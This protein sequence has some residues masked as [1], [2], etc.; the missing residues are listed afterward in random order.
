MG[1]EFK[2]QLPLRVRLQPGNF[3]AQWA[4]LARLRDEVHVTQDD[5]TIAEDA[6]NATPVWMVDAAQRPTSGSVPKYY[7]STEAV[8][9][10]TVEDVHN[11]QCQVS[12]GMGSPLWLKQSDGS[13][14]EVHLALTKFVRQ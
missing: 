10:G 9:K 5:F 13:V 8:F 4:I 3:A 1:N 6:E 12:G 2:K 14:I 7:K 11:P